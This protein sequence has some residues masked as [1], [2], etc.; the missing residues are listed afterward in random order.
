MYVPFRLSILLVLLVTLTGCG[1]PK[2]VRNISYDATRELYKEI[3]DLFCAEYR[4]ADGEPVR[5]EMSHGGSSVQAG[6]I[7]Q[8]APADIVTL[9]MWSDMTMLESKGFLPEAWWNRLPN[10]STPSFSTVVFVVRKGNPKEIKDWP[11]LVKPGVQVLTPNPKTGGGAKLNFLAAW[12]SVIDRGGSEEEAY[13]Y[14]QQLFKQVPV[15]DSGARG[16]AMTFARNKI[17]DVHLA[18]ENE[19]HREVAEFAGELELVYPSVSLIGDLPVAVVEDNAKRNGNFEVA[20]AYTKFLY[21]PAAQ[22]VMAK[23][24]YRPSD[25]KV[26]AAHQEKFPA[27]KL[28]KITAISPS[29]DDAFTKFFSNG[30]VYDRMANGEDYQ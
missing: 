1:Q 19:A 21:T 12:G 20:T 3:N 6:S 14:V 27:I 2:S 16:A 30:G 11:D 8:G 28:I 26:A 18:W 17:G 9:S 7:V 25:P 5:V 13:K 10:N 29:W 23:H 15:L 4:T 22:E 24:F